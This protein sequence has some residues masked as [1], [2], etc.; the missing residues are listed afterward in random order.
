MYPNGPNMRNAEVD[1]RIIKSALF[2][3]G[4]CVLALAAFP[5]L[6]IAQFQLN[7][8]AVSLGGT[9][10]ELT[11]DAG[12][13]SGSIWNKQ[14][15]NLTKPFDIQFSIQ[16]GCKNYTTGAD[17]IGFVFQPISINA[18]SPGGGMGFG[19]ITPSLNVEFDTYK[20]SW[21][22]AFCHVAIEKNGDV[23]HTVAADLLA[24]PAQ[25]SPTGAAIPDCNSH[26]G[27]I[28]WN[29]VTKVLNVYFD[30]SLR[31]SYT[32]DIVTTIFSG[33]P[34]VYWGFTAGTGGASNVQAVCIQN[35]YLTGLRD[36]AVCKGSG[37]PLAA[38]G[39]LTYSWSPA[40]GLSS[41][42]TANTLATPA[43]TTEYHVSITD[44]CGFTSLD[45]CLI[46][47][48]T[49]SDSITASVN[50]LCKGG[51]TGSAT[52]SVG[53]GTPPFTYNWTPTGGTSATAS[54][55]TAGTYTCTVT[56][57]KGC[58]GA[59]SVTLT[60]PAAL[61]VSVS[62]INA[63]CHGTCNGQLICIPN[64]G[65]S[66]YTYS[67]SSGCL[68]PGCNN[69]CAGTYHLD[70]TDAHGCKV[71]ADT[72]VSEPPALVLAMGSLPAHCNQADGTDSV[73]VSGGKPG[74]TYFWTPGAGSPTGVYHNL[75]P[76]TYTVTVNDLNN[77]AA[78]D[79]F[80][81]KNIQGVQATI[82]STVNVS[83]F[84][85][86]NG[87]A[88]ALGTGGSGGN[89]YSWVPSAATTATASNLQAG[90][91][92][93]TI[94][95]SYG[96]MAQAVAT[97]SQPPQL[98]VVPM[99]SDTIC[100]AQSDTLN[101]SGQ[102]G[103]PPYSFSWSQNGAAV[104][105]PVSPITTSTY[106]VTC[107]DANN[108]TSSAQTLVLY[109]NQALRVF[110]T[111]TGSI[112]P[113][114]TGQL[115]AAAS[116]GDG[117]YQY[118]W[119]PA[120]GLSNPLIPNP[121]ASPAITTTYTVYVHDGCSS[122]ADSGSVTITLYPATL[123]KITA[124]DTSGCVPLCVTFDGSSTPGCASAI[125]SFGDNSFG[126]KCDSVKHCYT[127]SGLYTVGIQITDANGCI[128]KTSKTG[129]VLVYPLPVPNF[130]ASPQPTDIISPTITFTD[131]SSGASAWVWTFGDTLLIPNT[132]ANP[133]H[134]YG[135]TG[136]YSVNLIATSAHGC[137]DSI[138]KPVCILPYFTFYAP[139]AFTPNGDGL[140]D[141]WTPIGIN[142][143]E[144]HYD[145]SIYDRWGNQLFHSSTWGK[146]WDGHANG[147]A[148]IAQEDTYIWVVSI[149]DFQGTPFTFRGTVTLIK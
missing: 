34:N 58:Q 24:G 97:I 106:T 116:G 67:W 6:S 139:N 76:G 130:N 8:T 81:V 71:A 118:S 74:Y 45:S 125:W 105:N 77:C 96:C 140:N 63:T 114:T 79:T 134:T 80:A 86:S 78:R 51:A 13:S 104:T 15:F 12:N 55:L 1:N 113:G 73:R 148:L 112:C 90:I 29:P 132:T 137:V 94:T 39:G 99:A 27:R 49:V 70:I 46:K 117:H 136:C 95:D 100:I 65:T 53:S 101:A 82:Q 72:S 47:I 23:D 22:P 14:T 43:T 133:H 36:T 37:V 89:M 115:G 145:V 10:Y 56:D 30:C 122:P 144:G 85:G 127:K 33:N 21:D 102:G 75:V 87:S 28:T 91:Y 110:P 142:I 5:H 62:G 69:V 60:E 123:P 38:K 19:G 61:A 84:G 146:G 103:T 32:G 11:P 40:A 25:L 98:T 26:P 107:T 7:G 9:C 138:R 42:N 35:S 66:P 17:G 147:G 16:L 57:A 3:R 4:L 135:D 54:A 131:A 48:N 92:T 124:K 64:G 143:D 141:V 129:Y 108:C 44:S 20:N 88:T 149:R 109:V 83:C 111:G 126:T 68:T 93:C 2:I 128:G 31:L 119:S 59:A 41:T 50:I 52:L 121:L 120:M 18:G